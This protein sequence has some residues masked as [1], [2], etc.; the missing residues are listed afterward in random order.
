MQT[1]GSDILTTFP[2]SGTVLGLDA[3]PVTL[4]GFRD[5]HKHCYIFNKHCFDGL[6]LEEI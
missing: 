4:K 1:F 5:P 6:A 3:K 2:L